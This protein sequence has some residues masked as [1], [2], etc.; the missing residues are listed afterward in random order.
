MRDRFALRL[1]EA[2]EEG[3]DAVVGDG[4]WHDG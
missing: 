2:F 1:V 3:L 4:L